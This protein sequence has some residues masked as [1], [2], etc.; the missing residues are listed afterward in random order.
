MISSALAFLAA[1]AAKI[2]KPETQ[3][4]DALEIAS[5][6]AQLDQLRA[7]L[8]EAKTVAVA[9]SQERDRWRALAEQ[10]RARATIPLGGHH[11]VRQITPEMLYAQAQQQANQPNLMQ[12]ID[13]FVCNCVPARQDVFRGILSG[14]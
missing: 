5:L 14:D 1:V 10:W 8:Y 9:M 2:V 12:Q 13:D 4:A 3:P 6:K 11:T 7:Q